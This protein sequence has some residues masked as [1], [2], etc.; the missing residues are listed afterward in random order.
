MPPMVAFVTGS[1]N[2]SVAEIARAISSSGLTV[3]S[4]VQM[5]KKLKLLLHGL[6]RKDHKPGRHA[7]L[8]LVP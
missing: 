6:E 1:E 7:G 5:S 4:G 2:E 3:V 8:V